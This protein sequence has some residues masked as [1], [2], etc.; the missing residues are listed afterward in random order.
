MEYGDEIASAYARN[1]TVSSDLIK[2]LCELG[3]LDRGSK[4]LEVGCGTAA[5]LIELVNSTGCYGC[6][7]EPSSEMRRHAGSDTPLELVMGSAEALPYDSGS[8]DLVFSVDVIHHVSDHLAHYREAE[9]VMASGGLVCT[10]TD[11]TEMIL[12][13]KPLSQYWPSSAD[14]DI[15]RYP[16]VELLLSY[17][18]KAGF[19]E[20]RTHEI[21]APF[22]ITDC[23][24]YRDRAYSCL[25]LISDAEFEDGLAR[26]ERDL[27]QG[28][29]AGV[30]QY[31]CVWG[32]AC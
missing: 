10:A 4:V 23:G 13:R 8:F 25:H 29:V 26:L 31:V 30:K 5:Y 19:A 6:G 24:P 3:Q 1:R 16:T 32:K 20:L 2:A 27:Q 14:A 11:S 9:R 15:E 12:D 28:P 22:A 17:M 18:R 21:R 7:V